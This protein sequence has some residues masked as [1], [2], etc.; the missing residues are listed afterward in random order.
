MKITKRQKLEAIAFDLKQSIDDFTHELYVLQTR[1][2]KMEK[3]LLQHIK[4]K[5]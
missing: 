1:M 5:Q 2:E 4:D 3:E